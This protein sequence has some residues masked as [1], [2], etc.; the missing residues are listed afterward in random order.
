MRPE[1]ARFKHLPVALSKDLLLYTDSTLER[2]NFKA[3]VI[4]IEI[5]TCDNSS[6]QVNLLLLNTNEV[7]KKVQNVWP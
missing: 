7:A 1:W 6:P 2:Q 4:H 3:V 5:I